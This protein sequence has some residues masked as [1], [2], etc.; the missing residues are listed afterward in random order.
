MV[1]IL[2]ILKKNKI[3]IMIGLILIIVVVL[4]VVA[5]KFMKNK[6]VDKKIS[7]ISSKDL[8]KKDMTK[9]LEIIGDEKTACETARDS[10]VKNLKDLVDFSHAT[11]QEMKDR[12]A[13]GKDTLMADKTK[14]EMQQNF[15]WIPKVKDGNDDI[16]NAFYKKEDSFIALTDELEAAKECN[17]L[18]DCI[19]YLYDLRLKVFIP[20]K[21][22]ELASSDSGNIFMKKMM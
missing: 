8:I 1:Q 17:N 18:K 3:I 16:E 9:E 22:V 20:V 11:L 13:N 10:C 21:K 2:D 4:A 15:Y 19:G 5:R 12:I 7:T 14:Y 6:K